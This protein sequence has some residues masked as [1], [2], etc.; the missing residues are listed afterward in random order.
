[1]SRQLFKFDS[2]KPLVLERGVEPGA[3]FSVTCSPLEPFYLFSEPTFG[4][5]IMTVL[6]WTPVVM[7]IEILDLEGDFTAWVKVLTNIA[8]TPVGWIPID[9]FDNVRLVS[10]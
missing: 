5:N 2:T 3:V 10:L 4:S 8:N 9:Y 7:V 1:V 6:S